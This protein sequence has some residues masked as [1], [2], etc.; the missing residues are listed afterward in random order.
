M[1]IKS[2]KHYKSNKNNKINKKHTK[3][4]NKSRKYVHPKLVNKIF[5]DNFKSLNGK[6]PVYNGKIPTKFNEIKKR[7]KYFAKNTLNLELSSLHKGQRK[8][9][10][11][12][13]DFINYYWP[14]IVKRKITDKVI[15]LYVGAAPSH[16]TTLLADLFPNWEFILVDPRSYWEKDLYKYKNVKVIQDFFKDEDCLKYKQYADRLLFISDIRDM[17]VTTH[18]NNVRND[19]VLEDMKFQM[20]WV[21]K[22][23]PLGSSLKFRLPY[24]AGKT[25]YL[26][27]TLK[28]QCWAP[29]SSTE[30][31]L[32]VSQKPTN[33]KWKM[34]SYDNTEHEE[35]AFYFN[36]NIRKY[37]FHHN[38]YCHQHNYDSAYEYLILKEFCEKVLK[39]KNNKLIQSKICEL[40]RKINKAVRVVGSIVPIIP[41]DTDTKKYNIK[42]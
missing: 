6:I 13:L 11:M 4:I 12:E 25:N 39:L 38:G 8:L 7:E 10:L 17:M 18:Q 41:K 2:K 23:N 35:R 36:N 24:A 9:C 27:G 15:V 32:Y 40:M 1:N 30:G 28:I 31:R 33:G 14:E 37:Y 16:H 29:K 22:I 34:K 21:K 42:T 3:K 19:I 26:D 5:F 20:N